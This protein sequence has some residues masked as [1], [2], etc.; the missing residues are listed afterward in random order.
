MNC[1]IQ[2]KKKFH[3]V[4][5]IIAIAAD[6]IRDNANITQIPNR[7]QIFE[8]FMGFLQLPGRSAE[9]I[10]GII[11]GK[12]EKLDIHKTPDKLVAQSYDG[13]AVMSGQ[14]SGVQAK[15]KTVYKNAIF[16]HAHQLNL[17]LERAAHQNKPV[18]VLFAS[19]EGFSTFF[20]RSPKRTQILD[21]RVQKR[22]PRGSNT[23][24]NF[25]SRIVS[26]VFTYKKDLL[27]CLEYIIDNEGDKATIRQAAGLIN[28]LKV[29][30]FNFSLYLFNK[31]LLNG[32]ILY[33]QL[34]QRQL[35][36]VKVQ[37]SI[38]DFIRAVQNIRNEIDYNSMDVADEADI[39][40]PAKRPR[41]INRNKEMAKEVCDIKKYMISS[42][43]DRF[44]VTD[45]LEVSLL[46]ET[47]CFSDYSVTFPENLPKIAIKICK[48]DPISLKQE[49]LTIYRRYDFRQANGAFHILQFLI[50]NNLSNVFQETVKL[51]TIIC[52][53]PMTTAEC[54][55]C[56]STL[57]RIKRFTRTTMGQDR[58]C[59]LAMCSI[60]KE[61]IQT[62][63]N[64][65]ELV[66]SIEK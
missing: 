55:R 40:I 53:T 5:T 38:A 11:L 62:T 35:D 43:T 25:S 49:L 42:I 64:F 33:N 34:Q 4:I 56:C 3:K 48:L 31:I 65:N 18:K 44:S 58:L 51:L 26:T 15:I 41:Y 29:P 21:T 59:A 7:V 19:I 52:T 50:D 10:N 28:Y 66:I 60:E 17:I 46:L 39:N 54:E 1:L 37:K 24:W 36:S 16:T 27:K 61:L 30:E 14:N 6:E 9:E 47:S 23:R 2:C 20:S 13:A 32:D 22:L 45:Y 8:H 63:E 57:N 12:L